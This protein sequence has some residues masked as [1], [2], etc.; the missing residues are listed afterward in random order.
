MIV[1]GRLFLE[2]IHPTSARRPARFTVPST[3]LIGLALGTAHA[4]AELPSPGNLRFSATEILTPFIVTQSC[5]FTC[6]RSTNPSGM[7]STLT[8][9]LSYRACALADSAQTLFPIIIG[10]K[11]LDWQAV[12]FPF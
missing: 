4:W 9:T 5:I 8:A 2:P 12:T 1:P 10:A 6:C 3:L 7:A 11:G